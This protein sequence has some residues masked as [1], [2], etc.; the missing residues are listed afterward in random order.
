LD[1]SDWKVVLSGDNLS[2]ESFS[3]N[4]C[5]EWVMTT[6]DKELDPV[7][8][9]TTFSDFDNGY[10]YTLV[11]ESGKE[12]HDMLPIRAVKN[13]KLKL[14]LAQHQKGEK[15]PFKIPVLGKLGAVALKASGQYPDGISES[16]LSDFTSEVVRLRDYLTLLLQFGVELES[17]LNYI[18]GKH[19]EAKLVL[20]TASAFV[21]SDSEHELNKR[22]DAIKKRQKKLEAKS[23]I[24]LQ[25]LVDQTQPELNTAEKKWFSDLKKLAVWIQK[26]MC[27]SID[28][29]ILI[30]L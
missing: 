1:I 9:F 24:I 25:I 19:K 18:L 30:F 21:S 6:F 20:S 5:V 3:V 14:T 7:R 13:L 11:T 23:T 4:S 22:L 8:E 29:V 2:R 10:S 12:F 17:R 28:D 16:F 26:K 15:A 27:L